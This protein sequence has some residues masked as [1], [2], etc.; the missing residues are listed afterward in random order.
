M[1]NNPNSRQQRVSYSKVS[2]NVFGNQDMQGGDNVFG[3]N[4][5]SNS[6]ANNTTSNSNIAPFLTQ[7]DNRRLPNGMNAQH[8]PGFMG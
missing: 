6:N 2:P 8:S 1:M 4:N 5:N 3:S 7:V